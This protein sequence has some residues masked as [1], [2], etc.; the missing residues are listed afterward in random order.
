M[1]LNIIG[2]CRPVSLTGMRPG[3][4]RM[5]RIILI[6]CSEN[7]LIT[8]SMLR[9]LLLI[10][11]LLVGYLSYSQTVENIRVEPEGDKIRIYYRIGGSTEAQLYNVT[12][13]CSMDGSPRF[14][15]KAVIGDVKGNIRGGKSYYTIV[16]DVFEDVDEVGSAEFFVKVELM[17]DAASPISPFQ[18]QSRQPEVKTPEKETT[19]KE[20]EPADQGFGVKE[21]VKK[22]KFDNRFLL[23][24][25]ASSFNL[26]GF[27][28]GTMGNWGF[29][30]SVRVGGYYEDVDLMSGSLTAGITKNFFAAGMYRLHGYMG[31][32][33][34][35]YFNTLDLET[36]LSNIFWNRLTLTLGME[37]IGYADLVFGIGIVL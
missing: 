27:T 18:D 32:G 17:D 4:C 23:S 36:G 26:L 22:G 34:G 33:I 16:W 3:A 11:V 6:L 12:L 1:I 9:Y 25:R 10:Q 7:F 30:G 24:Y 28:A 37:Y 15:P 20:P 21:Q 19:E 8:R 2:S 29:Y 14:E 5:Y 31:A 35:D 13:T